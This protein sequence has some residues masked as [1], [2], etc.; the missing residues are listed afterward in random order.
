MVAMRDF[1]NFQER[2][3]QCGRKFII[4]IYNAIGINLP[5]ESLS[6]YIL[7][8]ELVNKITVDT[9]KVEYLELISKFLD[10]YTELEFIPK[11]YLFDLIPLKGR[12]GITSKT[13]KE[14][15][16]HHVIK[17]ILQKRINVEDFKK[18]MKNASVISKIK[19]IR[20]V[21]AV[22][23]LASKLGEDVDN[24]SDK[25]KLIKKI[26]TGLKSGKYHPEDVE[27]H[28]GDKK[29]EKGKTSGKTDK[30]VKEVETI[31]NRVL[32][33]EKELQ[34]Q[35]GMINKIN[36]NI[37]EISNSINQNSNII[38]SFHNYIKLYFDKKE[39]DLNIGRTEK[40]IT[41]LRKEEL[42]VTAINPNLFDSLKISLNNNNIADFDILRD[43][44]AVMTMD[45]LMKLSNEID[46]KI[47]LD[48]F[49]RILYEET[50]K[51]VGSANNTV[52]IPLIR[53]SVTK[54]MNLQSGKFDSL[55]L[56][57]REKGWVLLEVGT[58]IGE[59]DVDW[60]DTGK[61]R[62]YY[63]KLLKL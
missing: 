63:L 39:A 31:N 42:N 44:L 4:E 43:G 14:D 16:I 38:H 26:Y 22:F 20:N 56:N 10:I 58:P 17:L 19:K 13:S 55:L 40:L 12:G 25:E 41:A 18:S 11:N 23:V 32:S 53:N 45:Y 6:D 36:S 57:C 61:N 60:L 35:K 8:E 3:I 50:I 21:D 48:L 37:I 30:L 5:D 52:K 51:L 24:K 15:L 47:S 27:K 49:Y 9:N 7:A 29:S 34:I 28:L 62:F 33:I 59:T 54:R 1:S 2:L 46:W